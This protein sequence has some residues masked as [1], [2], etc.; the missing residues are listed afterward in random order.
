MVNLYKCR[1]LAITNLETIRHPNSSY[2]TTKLYG[3]S[4]CG[5]NI[6]YVSTLR[7]SYGHSVILASLKTSVLETK[8]SVIWLSARYKKKFEFGG[9]KEWKLKGIVAPFPH[10]VSQLDTQRFMVGKNAWSSQFLARSLSTYINIIVFRPWWRELESRTLLRPMFHQR[11]V[12]FR[13]SHIVIWRTRDAIM[14]S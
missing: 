7:H 2:V 3:T 13:G 11:R 12:R 5:C 14:R 10:F 8:I 9:D 4:T 1:S 6:T